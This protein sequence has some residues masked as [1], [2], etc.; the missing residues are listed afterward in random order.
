MPKKHASKKSSSKSKPS[1]SKSFKPSTPSKAI[2]PTTVSRNT[3]VPRPS[4][5]REP[6]HELIAKRAYEIHI[7]GKGGSQTDNWYRAERELKAGL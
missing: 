1:P 4:I 5:K 6:S 3:P 7:S 2:P